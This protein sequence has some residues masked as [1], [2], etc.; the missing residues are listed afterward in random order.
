M[1][2]ACTGTMSEIIEVLAIAILEMIILLSNI[3]SYYSKVLE[4]LKLL[5][6]TP[7]ACYVN[8]CQ[9]LSK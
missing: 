5:C 2:V 8:D 7:L 3:A 4:I 1:H 9:Y 6:S